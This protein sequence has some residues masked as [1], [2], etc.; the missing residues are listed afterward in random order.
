MDETTRLSGLIGEIYD[1][2]LDPSLWHDVLQGIAGFLPGTF[3]NIF[4]Q[5][6]TRKS[7]QAFYSF[8]IDPKYL[9]LYFEKYV[10][11]NPMF[12]ATLFFEVGQVLTTQDIMPDEE[13]SKTRFFKEWIRPQGAIASSMASILEK[14]HTSIAGI[15]VGRSERQ[16]PVDESAL[17]RMELIVPHVRRAVTIGNVI[18]LHKVEA[19]ALADTL[20]G[21]AAGMFLVEAGARI[22]HANASAL[23]MADSGTVLRATRG[24]LSLADPEAD[25]V[26]RDTLAS[27]SAGDLAVGTK[28]IAVP[29]ASADGGHYVAHL[30][31]LTSGARRKAGAVYSAVAA[32]F[33]RKA[34]LNL[35]HPVEALAKAY[36]LTAAEMRVMMMIVQIGGV[37]EVAPVLGV[38]E[39]T[40]K[41]HLQHIFAKTGTVRQADL[42]KL[43]AGY[44]NPLV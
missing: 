6:A 27:A 39:T 10:H 3:V 17:K 25:Q 26:L 35:P 38:S 18:D 33:V 5:D 11:I 24:K 42:V 43:V 37:P 32:V 31:P 41:T 23:L 21:V 16:G 7:A 34:D 19:A 4:S 13:F 20:D 30:L 1:A 15:A 2:A 36:R 14:S 44:M 9:E 40:V 28:G 8:G 29:I 12:P 22:V